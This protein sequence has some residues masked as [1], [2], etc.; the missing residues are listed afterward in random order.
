MQDDELVVSG[1]QVV[2]TARRQKR[3]ER[4]RESARLSRRRRKQYLEVLEERVTQLSL[5]VDKG[6]RDHACQAIPCILQKR[7][8]VLASALAEFEQL[9]QQ[10]YDTNNNNSLNYSLW[11][12]EEGPLSRCAS[13]LVVLMT[14]F[15]QQLK[16]FSLPSENKFTLWLTLQNDVYFRGGRATSERLSAARIGER[17]SVFVA[18]PHEC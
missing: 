3:L 1:G 8:Q 18:P 15:T 13:S 2:V 17:V 6:R 16:S 9:K 4:N 14:F 10:Q 7:D 5:E 12:L 11:M